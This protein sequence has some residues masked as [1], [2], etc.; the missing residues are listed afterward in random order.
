MA[1]IGAHQRGACESQVNT[2]AGNQLHTVIEA[3][4]EPMLHLD[5]AA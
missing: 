2:M 4:P 1:R 3:V 5:A